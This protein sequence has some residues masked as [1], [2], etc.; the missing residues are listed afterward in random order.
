MVYVIGLGLVVLIA[1][2]IVKAVSGR[3]S[4]E[5]NDEEFEAEAKRSSHMGAAIIGLQKTLDPSHRVEYVQEQQQRVEADGA[6]SGDRLESGSP[7]REK[8]R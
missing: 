1:Y 6:E 5:M 3:R 7:V 8:I 2:G 4:S